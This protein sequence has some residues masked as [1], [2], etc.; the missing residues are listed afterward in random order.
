MVNINSFD[1]CLVRIFHWQ[2][3]IWW[4]SV[5]HID[6]YFNWRNLL[7]NTI[8][9]RKMNYSDWVNVYV[10]ELEAVKLC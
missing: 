10:W 2:K 5:N 3:V 9:L 8:L 4:K 6:L 7:Q 1:Y